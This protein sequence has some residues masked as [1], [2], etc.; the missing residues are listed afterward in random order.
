MVEVLKQHARVH[1][2]DGTEVQARLGETMQAGGCGVLMIRPE[3]I[4]LTSPDGLGALPATL[5]EVLFQGDHF[6]L[7]LSLA[8]GTEMVAK[9]PVGGEAL[10]E[11]GSTV[12]VTWGRT[13]RWCSATTPTWNEDAIGLPAPSFQMWDNIVYLDL[14]EIVG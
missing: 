10:P 7:R 8:D 9:R 12:G 1:L 11:A 13:T 3:R 5:A 4:A 2:P 14:R 6:R